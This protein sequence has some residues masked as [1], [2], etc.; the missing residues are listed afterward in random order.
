MFIWNVPSTMEWR[1][2]HGLIHTK[3]VRVEEMAVH[4]KENSKVGKEGMEIR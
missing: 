3:V 2:L 1:D 4:D